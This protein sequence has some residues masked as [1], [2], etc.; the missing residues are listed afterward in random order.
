MKGIFVACSNTITSLGFSDR[1]TSD[2][3]RNDE[4]GLLICSDRRLTPVP[5]PLSLIDTKVIEQGFSAILGKRM[6]AGKSNEFTRLEKLFILSVDDATKHIFQ[7]KPGKE[8]VLVI[9]T[10]KGNINLL[11]EKF[12]GGFASDRLFLWRL[13]QV[14][15]GFFGFENPPVIVSNACISGVLAI[16]HAARL[17]ASGKYKTAVVAG[18][19]LLSEFVISGFQSFQ[20]LS[21]EPCKPFDISRSGLSLGEGVGTIILTK[22]LSLLKG[23]QIEVAGMA[24]T[25]DAN[26][27]SGPSR[28]GEELALAIRRAIHEAELSPADIDFISAHGTGTVYN[29][30]MESRAIEI[31]GLSAVPVNSFKGF[32]GHTLGGAGV[33]ESAFSLA[34]MAENILYPSAGFSEPGIS[35][36]IRVIRKAEKTI[37]RN[38]VKTASGFGGCNAAVVFHKT[39]SGS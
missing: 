19:D 37:I 35:G 15:S 39:G 22:D 14:I 1:E 36:K 6:S 3:L 29:D 28:T 32:I 30:E 34:S 4:S 23:Q 38:I 25:N 17:L 24:T 16:G 8:T 7:Q 2:R 10:T 21:Q 26:H 20:A 27:I 11:E 12:E 9:S 5:V 13:A 33:I 18:G 31:A